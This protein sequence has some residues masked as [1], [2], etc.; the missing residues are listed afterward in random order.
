MSSRSTRRELVA[1]FFFDLGVAF[2][3]VDALADGRESSALPEHSGKVVAEIDDKRIDEAVRL[4]LHP[5]G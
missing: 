4:P 5:L 3:I 2:F 1:R